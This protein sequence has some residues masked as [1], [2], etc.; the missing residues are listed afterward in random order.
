MFWTGEPIPA[1]RSLIIP[2]WTGNVDIGGN[3]SSGNSE[4]QSLRIGAGLKRTDSD[5]EVDTEFA[6]RYAYASS[7]GVKSMDQGQ[8]EA[9]RDWS[10]RPSRWGYFML[11]TVEYD[12]FQAWTW[13]L[14][15]EAGPSYAFIRNRD[16]LLR[17]RVGVAFTKELEGGNPGIDPEGV[18]GV[19]FKYKI[20][21]RQKLFAVSDYLP[22]MIDAPQ[23]RMITKAGWEIAVDHTGRLKLKLGVE[24]L[25][26]SSPAADAA[27][28][29][30]VNYFVTL[31]WTF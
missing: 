23:Y 17:G 29:N 19:D 2:G 11:G 20:N 16:M 24:D 25:Y 9:R 27:H 4:S 13:R 22:S 7:F 31:G 3:G 10:F 5:D 1:T 6:A 26:E 18:V 14:S 21:P 30:D 28:R 12:E 8:F 15:A